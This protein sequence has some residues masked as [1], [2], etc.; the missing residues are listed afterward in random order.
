VTGDAVSSKKLLDFFKSSHSQASGCVEVRFVHEG[1]G[2]VLVRDSKATDGP[3]L[4]FNHR[5]WLA[6]LAGVR[7]GEFELPS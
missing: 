1:E 7:D 4:R 3:Q 6:F 5:E 2:A